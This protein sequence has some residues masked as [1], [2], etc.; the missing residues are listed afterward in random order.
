MAQRQVGRNGWPVMVALCYKIYADGRLGR[1]SVNEIA[2]RTGLTHAQIARGIWSCAIKVSQYPLS[3]RQRR[4][5]AVWIGRLMGMSPNTALRGIYGKP[6]TSNRVI[7]LADCP[8]GQLSL[9][10]AYS[11]LEFSIRDRPRG[12]E[13]GFPLYLQVMGSEITNDARSAPHLP[14]ASSPP[15]IIQLRSKLF[16]E[17]QVGHV[18]S[19]IDAGRHLPQ[20]G[21]QKNTPQ[22][23]TILQRRPRRELL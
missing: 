8:G 22:L 10:L 9:H 21:L 11:P 3:A 19:F 18:A 16:E 5:S 14:Q 23:E 12:R 13:Q 4:V 1:T 2:R 6:S 20:Y 7:Y 15:P 17:P